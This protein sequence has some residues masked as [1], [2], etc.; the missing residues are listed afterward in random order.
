MHIYLLAIQ[1]NA[2]L[3]GVTIIRRNSSIRN[4]LTP[5]HRSSLDVR[6]QMESRQRRLS[7]LYLIPLTTRKI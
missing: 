5:N 7:Q 4:S 6:F 3:T 1:S 2:L